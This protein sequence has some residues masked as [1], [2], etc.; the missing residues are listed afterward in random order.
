MT[1]PMKIM[2]GGT[3][4]LEHLKVNAAA[5]DTRPLNR[6]DRKALEKQMA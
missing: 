6:K 2:G 5:S 1:E 4:S 3:G